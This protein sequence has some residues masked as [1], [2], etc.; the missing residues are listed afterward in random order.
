MSPVEE[1]V[2]ACFA[3]GAQLSPDELTGLTQLGVSE[4]T[5]ALMMLE[6]QRR[7]ARRTDGRYETT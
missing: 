5:T 7:L 2:M 6:L 3:G 1:R 4:V